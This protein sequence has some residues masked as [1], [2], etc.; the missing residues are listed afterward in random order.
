MVVRV[1][2]VK[3][4]AMKCNEAYFKACMERDVPLS[5]KIQVGMQIKDLSPE[6]RE[7]NGL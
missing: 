1:G 6:E 2:R 4:D 5:V 3:D 7:D